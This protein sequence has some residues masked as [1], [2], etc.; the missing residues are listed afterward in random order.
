MNPKNIRAHQKGILKI[1]LKNRQNISKILKEFLEL[2]RIPESYFKMALEIFEKL[3]WA[4][5]TRL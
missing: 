3:Q 1:S 4:M 5:L 2:S